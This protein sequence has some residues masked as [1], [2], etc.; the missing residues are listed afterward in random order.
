MKNFSLVGCILTEMKAIK[1]QL[2]R[3]STCTILRDAYASMKC[4]NTHTYTH[5]KFMYSIYIWCSTY[6]V[7][8]FNFC[9]KSFKTKLLAFFLKHLHTRKAN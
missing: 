5:T 8:W 9:P 1:T 7:S 4:M 2:L 6:N 3:V